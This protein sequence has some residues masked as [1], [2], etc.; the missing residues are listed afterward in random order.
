MRAQAA[1]T[2][3]NKRVL[4]FLCEYMVIASSHLGATGMYADLISQQTWDGG[5]FSCL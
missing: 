3:Y 1:G 5:D 4:P 2:L